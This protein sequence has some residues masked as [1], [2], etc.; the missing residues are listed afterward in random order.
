MGGGGEEGAK[1]APAT[2]SYP[3]TY[4]ARMA[5]VTLLANKTIRLLFPGTLSINGNVYCS[6]EGTG[7][8]ARA[9]AK[10]LFH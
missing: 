1:G 7:S 3:E 10:L 6:L 4:R 8:R 9:V 5:N 2:K